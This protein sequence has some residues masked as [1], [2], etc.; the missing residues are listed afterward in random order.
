MP[1]I[2]KSVVPT[3]GY[4][5][6]IHFRCGITKRYHMKPL[7]DSIDLYRHFLVDEKLFPSV[8]ISPD[9]DA[10]VWN[11]YVDCGCEE[12]WRGGKEVHS[13]FDGLL[14]PADAAAI[15]HIDESTLRKAL[16]DGRLKEGTDAMKFGKQWIIT[17]KA[18]NR[19][20]GTPE[21]RRIEQLTGA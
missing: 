6:T 10:V 9:G 8:S 19:I 18:M 16:S 14:S 21:E 3:S 15:W 7:I 17:V 20:Y 1:H 11:E 4:E 5:L 12:L 2:I 13:P